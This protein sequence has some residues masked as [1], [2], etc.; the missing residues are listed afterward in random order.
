MNV[1]LVPYDTT[2]F[3]FDGLTK[4]VKKHYLSPT[5]DKALIADIS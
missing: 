3:V 5:M 4:L 1:N 2:I